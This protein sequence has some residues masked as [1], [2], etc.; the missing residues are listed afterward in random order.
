M[1]M[2]T[3]RTLAVL[4]ASIMMAASAHA[5]TIYNKDGLK[6]EVKGDIQIQLRQDPGAD[7]QNDV[8]YDDLELKNKISY[9]LENDMTVF[10]GLD[11]GFK[12]AADKSD[13]GKGPHL[14][15]AYVGLGFGDISV[16][17]GK[18]TSAGDEFGIEMA[19]EEMIEDTFKSSGAQDGDDLLKIEGKFGDV[20]VVAAHEFAGKSKEGSAQ[21]GKFSD[22]FIETKIAGLELGAA[23]QSYEA[24]SGTNN[25]KGQPVL[26]DAVAIYG[27]SAAYDA[28]VVKVAAD[29]SVAE[30][31]R[32]IMNVA[33]SA[34]VSENT[35]IAV[36]YVSEDYD[37]AGADDITGW[38]ANVTHKLQKN[39]SV[40][41]EVEDTDKK[42][43]DMG[44][45]A[46][47]QVK[48]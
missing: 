4:L 30:D 27:I 41:A 13:A 28:K 8:E 42:D 16:S 44:Y 15:E 12:N 47:M 37:A 36:G 29:Y 39:V 19:Y 43:V 38:Y 17:M 26:E 3:S 2:A 46:G 14:E 25:S 31:D 10:A 6:Y 45:L 32:T 40:F 20:T 5:A 7:M 24:Y 23:Y 21:N 34:P 48:F 18:T 35:K 11:F 1:K 9:A 33:A 22:I